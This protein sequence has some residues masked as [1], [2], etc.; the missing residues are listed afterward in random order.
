TQNPVESHGTYPLP[1][2]QLD[3]FLLQVSMGYPSRAEEVAILDRQGSDVS[4]ETVPPVISTEDILL[5]QRKVGE[6]YLSPDLKGFIADLVGKT[7]VHPDVL[8]GAS[9][10]G[11]L[12]LS[13][14]GRA[15][16]LIAERDF[17]IP[18]DIIGIMTYALAHRLVLKPE[19]QIAG[20]NREAIL[21][22][23]LQNTRI[24]L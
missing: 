5:L 21:H 15:M 20:K 3:R 17:V 23:I 6:V 8:L 10:R 19:A 7:R 4:R 13:L 22:E 2:A 1:E 11:F 16:A 12:A 14:A 24:P 9:P 18:D